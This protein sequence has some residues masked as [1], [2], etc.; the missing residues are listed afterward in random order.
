[1]LNKLSKAM[2]PAFG[3]EHANGTEEAEEEEEEDDEDEPCENVFDAATRGNL[4]DPLSPLPFSDP[5]LPLEKLRFP[6]TRSLCQISLEPPLPTILVLPSRRL[7]C[8]L[9]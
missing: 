1:M 4:L 8:G 2:G 5:C 7:S 9:Q 3:G 6:H